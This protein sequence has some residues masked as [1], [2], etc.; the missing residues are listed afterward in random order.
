MLFLDYESTAQR[1]KGRLLRVLAGMGM[2]W[3]DLPFI[4]W[5]GRGRPLPE[6]VPALRRK[7]L[8]LRPRLIIIDSAALAAGG[9]PE[10][11]EIAIRYFN[12]LSAL[13]TPSHTLGHV[14]KGDEDEFPFGSIFWS[15]SARLT[16][17]TKIEHEDGRNV[18]HIGLF[19]RKSNE[20][21][22]TAPFG[23]R[24]EFDANSV[25]FS[26]EE[27]KAGTK[28]RLAMPGRIRDTLRERAKSVKELAAEL[29]VTDN[30]VRTY[31]SRISD[32]LRVGT[33]DDKSGLWGLKAY[34]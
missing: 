16:W 15:N 3:N 27:L 7:I 21:R 4:Y 31:L 28:D 33:A 34:E 24:A 1:I 26:R 19:N 32:A 10:K 20:E 13:E 29:D 11:A 22:L 18:A 14:T 25:R 23:V 9:E 6:I 8:D 12:A 30:A 2:D 5:P 17:N